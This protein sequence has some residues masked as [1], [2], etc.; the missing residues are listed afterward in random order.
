MTVF[1]HSRI[2]FEAYIYWDIPSGSQFVEEKS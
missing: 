2:S 1:M